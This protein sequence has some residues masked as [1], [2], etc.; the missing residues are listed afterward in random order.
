[1]PRKQNPAEHNLSTTR[2][3]G[4][5]YGWVVAIAGA[6]TILMAANYQY[7][8]GVFVKPLV[9]TFGWSRAVISG[10]V[11]TRSIVSGIAGPV[12]GALS[13]RYGPRR[14]IL[15]GILLVGLSYALGSRITSLWH[16]YLFLGI[17]TG[18]G[19]SAAL[20][21]TVTTVNRW[22]GGKSALANGIVFSGFSLSQIVIPPVATYFIVRYGWATCFTIL[23][24]SVLVLGSLAW[25]FIR[26]PSNTLNQLRQSRMEGMPEA[27]MVSGGTGDQ[28]KLS[29]ALR[30]KTLW[31][32]LLIYMIV[33]ICY[34][35]IAIH[36]IVA[37]IDTGINPEVAAIILTLGGVT[38][39]LGRLALSAA[40][41]KIG[42]RVV[43]TFCLA[44]QVLALSILVRAS[45][46]NM[47]YVAA[48][49]V[50]LGYGGVTPIVSTLLGSYF[51]TRSLGS[52][53]GTLTFAYTLGI[54][55][56]P[57]LAGYIFDVTGNYS[58]AFLS[59][60]I[61]MSAALL[62]SLFLKPPKK[63]IAV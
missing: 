6:I 57:F 24:I 16:L 42:G 40:A 4:L 20:V 8:F 29:E 10:C 60:A 39:I 26:T 43:L 49:I 35:M 28:Y 48:A 58:I 33:A 5:F 3:G 1:M 32:M 54:A 18:I 62:L 12:V 46:L 13:D 7:S 45:E 51:G 23:G 36:V 63:N 11:S 38:N 14:F 22:F 25:C 31:I 30:T 56:G 9:N 34:Q 2:A 47:F 44:I 17:L 50:G 27:S 55:I 37:A 59:A 41:G 53:Y 19:F 61:V 21:P 52:I 15:M